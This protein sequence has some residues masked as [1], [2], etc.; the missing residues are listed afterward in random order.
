[1]IIEIAQVPA[2]ATPG[3][4]VGHASVQG[5]SRVQGTADN[6]VVETFYAASGSGNSDWTGPRT[7]LVGTTLCVTQLSHLL[8]LADPRPRIVG[9]LLSHANLGDHGGVGDR[10]RTVKGMAVLGDFSILSDAILELGV[11]QV[12]ISLPMAFS[13]QI[14][15]LGKQLD[16][17]AVPWRF[18]PALADQLAGRRPPSVVEPVSSAEMVAD[19]LDPLRLLNRRVEPLDEL[20]V[21][22]ALAGRTV[23][24]TGAGTPIGSALAQLIDRFAPGRLVLVDRSQTALVQTDRFLDRSVGDVKR[25]IVEHDLS[26]AARTRSVVALQRPSVIFHVA[27]PVSASIE[28]PAEATEEDFYG[29][30][31]IA[32]AAH[33]VGAE[34]FIMISTD[35]A[36]QPKDL[37][38]RTMRLAELYVQHVNTA[39]RTT[40]GIV[41]IGN[42]LGSDCRVLT[43]WS[44]QLAQDQSIKVCH[45]DLR[46]YLMTISEVIH[47]VLQSAILS[48]LDDPSGGEIFVLNKGEP[49]HM[50]VLARRYITLHGL[51][52][53]VDMTVQCGNE[54]D[55]GKTELE[56]PPYRYDQLIATTCSAIRRIPARP[57]PSKQIE[58]VIASLDQMRH[59]GDS[60]HWQRAS[61]E[62]VLALLQA[63]VPEMLYA[64]AS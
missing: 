42:V 4:A 45:P 32:D 15:G 43:S 59:S 47:L 41:R 44:R 24:I 62:T 26:D 25:T 3:F 23:M 58:Q 13:R 12:L 27:S 56:A 50:A 19:T 5:C 55:R 33:M 30:R 1:M 18:M 31:S 60:D 29:T 34:R 40:Y 61:R 28:D 22:K 49:I 9:C 6:T 16:E 36:A 51:E 57:M 11:E 20:V 21:G 46:R 2:A 17:T 14:E 8:E 35:Q 64:T 63:A 7:L 37:R 39:S 54:I 52:P 38:G 48:G 10:A 53:D